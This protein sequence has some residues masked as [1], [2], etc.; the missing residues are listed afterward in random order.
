MVKGAVTGREQSFGGQSGARRPSSNY[1]LDEARLAVQDAERFRLAGKLDKARTTCLSV[2]R[3][4]PDFV[5]ALHTVGLT[6]ADNKEYERALNNLHRASMLNPYD[7]NTLTALAGVYLRMGFTEVAA[8]S[9]EHALKLAPDNAAIH[10][11]LGEVY[12]ENKEYEYSRRAYERA[13][14]LDPTFTAAE[15]GLARCCEHIGDVQ[16]SAR[17]YNKVVADGSRSISAIYM[18]SQL[19]S[20][21]VEFDV[22]A[23]L[24]EAASDPHTAA[25][26]SSQKQLGFARATALDKAGQYQDAWK[27]ISA[28]RKTERSEHHQAYQRRKAVYDRVRELMATEPMNPI[29]SSQDNPDLPISLFVV[30]PSRS[31]KTTTERLV[32]SL[33]GVKRGYENPIVENAVRRAFKS[34]G[35]PTRSRS[36][37]LPEGLSDVFRNYYMEE[38][39]QRAPGARVF[40]NTLPSRNEDALRIASY[41][42]NTRFVFVKRNL[43]DLVIRIYM[44]NYKSGNEYAWNIADIRHYL[45]WCH[46]MMDIMAERMPDNAIIV[47]YEDLVSDPH[48]AVTRVAELC[49]LHMPEETLPPVGDDRGCGA[50]YE[51]WIAPNST[52]K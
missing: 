43:E 42:P 25:K 33:D 35:F 39:E 52:E 37:E 2:L 6:L 3:Q 20:E 22:L 38:L 5:A 12:S 9:L 23:L 41:L 19:P 29:P 45:E 10:A 13:L 40:T 4:Y 17:I 26:P 1:S 21:L 18:L 15:I 27:A 14:E 11:T 32:G 49:G 36:L 30:G 8:R 50:P 16:T 28:V 46:D 7:A 44:R 24:D 51:A 31:G 34:S 47:H 48:A